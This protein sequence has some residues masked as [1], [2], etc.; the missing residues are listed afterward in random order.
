MQYPGHSVKEGE[1]DRAIV[2]AVQAQLLAR[3]CGPVD[4]G[5]V[6][7]PKTKAAVKLFQGRHVDANGQPL[8]NDGKV[9]PLTWAALFGEGTVHVEHVAASPF[10]VTVLATAGTQV[11]V[12]ERPRNSN[13]GPEVNAYLQRAGVPLSLAADR[14]PWCC[15]FVYWCFDEAARAAGRANPMVKTAGCLDHWN[16]APERG[17][18]RIMAGRAASDPALVGPGMVFIMD[19]G[20]GLGHTGFVEQVVG[21]HVH[22]IEGNTDPTQSREGGGVYRLVRKM[23]DIKKGYIDYS[24]L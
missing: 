16:R 8:K 18:R 19:F 2:R 15:A 21:G 12:L 13:S 14:K 7:G 20:R 4:A 17:A 11:G 10:L 5:G 3:H 23:A 24:V 22:T 6:F 1:S 9:G